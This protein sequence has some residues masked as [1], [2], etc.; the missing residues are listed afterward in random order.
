[1]TQ[2]CFNVAPGD[3]MGRIQRHPHSENAVGP[4]SYGMGGWTTE[5]TKEATIRSTEGAAVTGLNG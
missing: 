4:Q 2:S 3:P 1:M 5:A